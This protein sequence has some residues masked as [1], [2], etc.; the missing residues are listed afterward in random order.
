VDSMFQF[1]LE[2]GGDRTKHCRN[3]N[4]R[5]RARLGSMGRK[6]DMVRQRDDVSQRRGGTEEGRGGNNVSWADANLTGL[7]NKENT[8]GRFSW[9]KWTVKI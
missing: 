9:Y 4:Q 6:R 2:R 8:R 1:W 7:K 5:Q 3:M